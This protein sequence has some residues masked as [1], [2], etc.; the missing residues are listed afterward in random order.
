MSLSVRV[1]NKRKPEG[2]STIEGPLL[3]FEERLREAVND[4][5]EGMRKAESSWPIH[6]IH[7]ERNRF[8]Y[9]LYYKQQEI[10]R[11][12]YEFLVRE[13]VVDAALISKWRKPGFEIVCSL[14]AIDKANSNF[15]TASICRVPLAQRGGQKGYC[16]I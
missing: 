14:G 13:K 9:D 6:R 3:Q 12:L 15:G 1:K 5:H 10:S 4:P 11:E 7:Y 16:G 2:W 8:I